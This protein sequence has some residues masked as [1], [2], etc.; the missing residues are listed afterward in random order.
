MLIIFAAKQRGNLIFWVCLFQHVDSVVR[1]CFYQ[2]RQLYGQSDDPF[3]TTLCAPW[4]MR[5]SQVAL[6]TVKTVLYGVSAKVAR[7]LQAVGYYTLPLDWPSLMFAEISISLRHCGLVRI[8]YQIYLSARWSRI[9]V[10]SFIHLEHDLARSETTAP[11]NRST[12]QM[13]G[14]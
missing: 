14:V 10:R 1:S 4:Y 9:C 8:L 7:R 3:K 11:S 13:L 6:T 2:L 5:S 12:L